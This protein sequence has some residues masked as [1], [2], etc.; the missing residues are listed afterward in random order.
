MELNR[1]NCYQERQDK[2]ELEVEEKEGVGEMKAAR[3]NN[4]FGIAVKEARVWEDIGIERRGFSRANRYIFFL[5]L[6]A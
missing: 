3:E 5:D 2:L 4:Y 1:H 6:A